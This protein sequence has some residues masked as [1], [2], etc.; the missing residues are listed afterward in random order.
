SLPPTDASAIQA[1]TPSDMFSWP[2]PDPALTMQSERTG[3]ENKGYAL[4]GGVVELKVKKMATY[5]LRS[6]MQ[7]VTSPAA[8]SGDYLHNRSGA[9]FAQRFLIGLPHGFLFTLALRRS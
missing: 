4:K 1:V 5:I 3:I 8:S 7:P 9:R 2:G 6:T